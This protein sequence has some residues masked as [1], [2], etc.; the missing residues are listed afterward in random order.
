MGQQPGALISGG[1]TSGSSMVT[2]M[3]PPEFK[4]VANSI[5]IWG[6]DFA[7]KFA[8]SLSRFVLNNLSS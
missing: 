7:K 8:K 5:H 4:K 3:L 2:V 1:L 6:S